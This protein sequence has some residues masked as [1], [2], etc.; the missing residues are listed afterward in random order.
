ML[1]CWIGVTWYY[2]ELR[3]A[4]ATAPVVF[5]AFSV[6]WIR[7]PL[8]AG[9]WYLIKLVAPWPQSNFVIA[10]MLPGTGTVIA[11]MLIAI[12]AC[13]AAIRRWQ[14][15]GDG[16]AFLG[17]W[18]LGAALAPSLAATLTGVSETPV[19]ERCLYLPSVGAA[20][21]LGPLL[22]HLWNTRW[23][24]PA[25]WALGLLATLYLATAV[26]RGTVWLS[27]LRLWTDTTQR[28]PAHGLPWLALGK[29]RFDAGD[30]QGAIEALQRARD[31]QDDPLGRAIT[32]YNLGTIQIEGGNL[33]EAAR[34]FTA[35]VEADSSYAQGH[36]GLGR[37]FY[38]RATRPGHSGLQDRQ[39][40][41]LLDRG[42]GELEVA[43]ARDPTSVPIH[44]VLAMVHAAK[45]DLLA[46]GTDRAAAE[47]SYARAIAHLD[48][49]TNLDP[50]VAA[51]ADV[52]AIRQ[53]VTIGLRDAEAQ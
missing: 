18:W 31:L 34:S 53:R 49:V 19:A 44:L 47:S 17:L 48:A 42:E 24:Q 8:S 7:A 6:E 16:T 26:H 52:Q 23:A 33:E 21:V 46:H 40:L 4:G 32:L 10:D 3:G 11:V 20:L 35:A 38:E 2:F 51:I 22:C 28:M 13:A 36:Y 9:A 14:A 27:D 39:R 30:Q 5:P 25:S 37:I 12:G 1:L 15:S 29:A 41:D 50:A 45:G 43:L